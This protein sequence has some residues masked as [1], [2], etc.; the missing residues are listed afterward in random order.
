MAVSEVRIERNRKLSLV[1]RRCE[2][3]ALHCEAA[4]PVVDRGVLGI[5]GEQGPQ[6]GLRSVQTPLSRVGLD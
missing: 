5:R 6:Y 2:I 4:E 1:E 3:L